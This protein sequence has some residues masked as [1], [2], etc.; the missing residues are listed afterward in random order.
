MEQLPQHNETELSLRPLL[1]VNLN[2]GDSLPFNLVPMAAQQLEGDEL[3]RFNMSVWLVTQV[4]SGGT[5]SDL[6]RI[7]DTHTDL[8]D[9]SNAFPLYGRERKIMG[10]VEHLNEQIG[11]LPEGVTSHI[12]GMYPDFSVHEQSPAQYLLHVGDEIARM[13]YEESQVEGEQRSALEQYRHSLEKCAASL[14]RY[15]VS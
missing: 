2:S 1:E 7:V 12:D 5:Y 11:A 10:A 3:A 9:T 14:R 4:G 6:L 15:G 8:V 13:E